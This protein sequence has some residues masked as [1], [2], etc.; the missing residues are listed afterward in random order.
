MLILK[1]LVLYLN[2]LCEDSIEIMSTVKLIKHM[3]WEGFTHIWK[4]LLKIQ[5]IEEKQHLKNIP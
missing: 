1:W 2:D 3:I 5:I 4:M